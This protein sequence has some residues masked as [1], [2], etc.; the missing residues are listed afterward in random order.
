MD[1]KNSIS[2]SYHCVGSGKEACDLP[3]SFIYWCPKH[4]KMEARKVAF[5]IAD[6]ESVLGTLYEQLRIMVGDEEAAHLIDTAMID[7][8]PCPWCGRCLWASGPCCEGMHEQSK[9]YLQSP[10]YQSLGR[11]Q[12]EREVHRKRVAKQAKRGRRLERLVAKRLA[13]WDTY[14]QFLLD[15]GS[16][17]GFTNAQESE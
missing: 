8:P 4:L 12:F 10:E 16:W 11:Q 7:P 3:V 9:R 1:T 17:E 2:P 14:D 13:S 6:T 5:Q 15:Q